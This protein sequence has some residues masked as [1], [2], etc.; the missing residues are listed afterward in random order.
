MFYNRGKV[1][2]DQF[3]HFKFIFA[4]SGIKWEF[5]PQVNQCC[6][7][8]FFILC[9]RNLYDKFM[10]HFSDYVTC[11]CSTLFW[12][13]QILFRF[14][15]KA[16]GV[17]LHNPAFTEAENQILLHCYVSGVLIPTPCSPELWYSNMGFLDVW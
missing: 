9:F 3:G 6:C 13:P 7:C 11:H 14:A 17:D 8:Q 16:V 5:S 2:S 15:M 12:S 10:A 1:L 4:H